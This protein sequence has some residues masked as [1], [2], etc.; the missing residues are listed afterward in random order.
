MK[1]KFI[2]ATLL[3]SFLF[4][5]GCNLGSHTGAIND[6]AQATNTQQSI[7]NDD[8]VL[9]TFRKVAQAN[10]TQV[11]IFNK[12]DANNEYV[13]ID[14]DN[15][16]D[17]TE[18]VTIGNIPGVRKANVMSYT[19]NG[20][21]IDSMT[22]NQVW[23]GAYTL[24]SEDIAQMS[25]IITP[26]KAY[27]GLLKACS[28]VAA[29]SIDDVKLYSYQIASPTYVPEHHLMYSFHLK[30]VSQTHKNECFEARYDLSDNSVSCTAAMPVA[31]NM[32]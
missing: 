14:D 22:L 21:L 6:L 29:F 13:T 30:H 18:I 8:L 1:T 28:D 11:G 19:L 16:D 15:L 23:I 3:S 32:Q 25:N 10:S 17:I 5:S 26:T 9:A 12:L 24:E 31:C 4:I 7:K 2:L 27:H 20:D